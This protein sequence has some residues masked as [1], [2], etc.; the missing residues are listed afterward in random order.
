MLAKNLITRA[1]NDSR[2]RSDWAQ[3]TMEI[4]IMKF[5][6]TKQKEKVT[7]CSYFSIKQTFCRGTNNEFIKNILRNTPIALFRPVDVLF[8]RARELRQNNTNAALILDSVAVGRVRLPR[9]VVAFV[10]PIIEF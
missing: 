9:C 6:W 3:Y 8:Q 10:D 4:I 2:Q 5:K 7:T 1:M